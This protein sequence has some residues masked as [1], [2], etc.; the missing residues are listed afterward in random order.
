MIKVSRDR[1]LM[2]P[3][4]ISGSPRHS[5]GEEEPRPVSLGTRLG[6]GTGIQVA[7]RELSKTAADIEFVQ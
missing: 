7:D 3:R 6:E 4:T 2:I 5:W 1:R